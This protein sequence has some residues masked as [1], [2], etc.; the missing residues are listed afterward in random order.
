MTND[1]STGGPLNPTTNGMP[2]NA[3][4]DAL[5]D[6]IAKATNLPGAMIRPRW[7]PTPPK[8]PEANEDW[9][10]F[11]IIG[12]DEEAAQLVQGDNEARLHTED[13]LDVLFSFY[14][15]AA[16]QNARAVKNAL[17]I[18]QNRDP[19]R[20]IGVAVVDAAAINPAADL[21]G[22]RWL[23]RFDLSL[24]LRQAENAVV[25]IKNMAGIAIRFEK[26]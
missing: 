2:I 13:L 4:E 15:P 18:G 9:C 20:S 8:Q 14:G 25:N 10:A 22:G 17:H 1:S 5:H 12:I 11:G 16:L 6:L 19:L 3:L 26:G 7:Q 23:G 24:V 21:V